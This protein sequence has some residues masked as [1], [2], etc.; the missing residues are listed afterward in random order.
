MAEETGSVET[1]NPVEAD[2][3]AEATSATS[4]TALKTYGR[5]QGG[6]HS[7]ASW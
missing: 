2:A 3:P 5:R 1:G 6:S 7:Y 4:G